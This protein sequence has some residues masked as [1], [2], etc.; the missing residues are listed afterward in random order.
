ME[1]IA[2]FVGKDQP[3]AGFYES[4]SRLYQQIAAD[5]VGSE[6]MTTALDA[7]CKGAE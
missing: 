4:A 3:G 5:V 6:Q 7:F 1:E 2:A